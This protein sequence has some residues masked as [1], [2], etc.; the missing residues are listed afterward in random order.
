MNERIKR[1]EKMETLLNRL[2]DVMNRAD[3]ALSQLEENLGNLKELTD[4]YTSPVWMADYQAD[5]RGEIPAHI[6]RGVLSEDGIY[7]LLWQYRCL[8]DTMSALNAQEEEK[9]A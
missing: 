8:L 7:N 1:I 6:R 2:T 9:Q 5:E 3:E 4:Y